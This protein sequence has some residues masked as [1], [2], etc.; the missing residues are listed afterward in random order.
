MGLLSLQCSARLRAAARV[1]DRVLR[2][3]FFGVYFFDP[4]VVGRELLMVSMFVF[5]C[6]TQGYRRRVSSSLRLPYSPFGCQLPAQAPLLLLGQ[7][8]VP[9][10]CVCEQS[11]RISPLVTTSILIG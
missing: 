8:R 2:L 6:F 7:S 3:L 1:M 11:A 5:N 9:R 10:L 4:H